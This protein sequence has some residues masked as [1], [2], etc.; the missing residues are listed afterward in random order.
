MFASTASLRAHEGVTHPPRSILLR[1]ARAY[2]DRRGCC[3]RRRRIAVASRRLVAP[4]VSAS[5]DVTRT[6]PLAHVLR[7]RSLVGDPHTRARVHVMR[8]AARECLARDVNAR[9]K[10]SKYDLSQGREKS[11][12][13]ILFIFAID[14]CE[15]AKRSSSPAMFLAS[16]MRVK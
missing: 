4:A 3:C 15:H 7:S 1:L 8:I 13:W 10:K 14:E 6:T 12:E 11:T 16:K 5:R 9:L 2:G